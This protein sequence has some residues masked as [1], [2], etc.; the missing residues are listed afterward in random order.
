MPADGG[1]VLHWHYNLCTSDQTQ[2]GGNR[3]KNRCDW[4]ALG[5]SGG[6][7]AAGMKECEQNIANEGFVSGLPKNGT[8]DLA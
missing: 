8:S 4:S 3:R 1:R 5:T 6:S 7:D 2:G